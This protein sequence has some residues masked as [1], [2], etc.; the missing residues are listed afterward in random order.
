MRPTAE[1]AAGPTTIEGVVRQA[2]EAPLIAPL[3]GRA[4]VCYEVH[5]GLLGGMKSQDAQRFYL[6]YDGGRALVEMDRFRLELGSLARKQVLEVLDADINAIAMQLSDLK[7]RLRQAQGHRQSVLQKELR[8]LK[9]LATLL[10][11]VRAHARGNV[12]TGRTLEGQERFIAAQSTLYQADGELRQIPSR[13]LEQF[14]TILAAGQRAR[15]TG[16]ARWGTGP[17]QGY[18]DG[19]RQLIIFAPEDGEVLVEGQG[20]REAQRAM[21][22]QSDAALA[23]DEDALIVHRDTPDARWL[24]L[25]V[26]GA[27]ALSLLYVAV[28]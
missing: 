8:E 10:C 24:W 15:V 26:A 12:H 16:E 4:C 1:V 17:S 2:E 6:E 11:A 14:D 7:V 22:K 19:A 25:A 21:A 13:Y 9:G 20:A 18:R 23:A 28:C 5:R 27:T 3:S